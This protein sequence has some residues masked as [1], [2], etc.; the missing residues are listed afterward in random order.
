MGNKARDPRARSA[1][2]AS[3]LSPIHTDP[4]PEGSAL[5][6][7]LM[8]FGYDLCNLCHPFLARVFL[9]TCTYHNFPKLMV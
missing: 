3:A 4:R 7:I 1:P 9:A 6:P 5:S 2:R 8:V